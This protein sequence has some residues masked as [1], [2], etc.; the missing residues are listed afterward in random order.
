MVTAL[1]HHGWRNDLTPESA[2][3]RGGAEQDPIRLTSAAERGSELCPFRI[4]GV[5][6]A[7][8]VV[9]ERKPSEGA[10]QV[11]ATEGVRQLCAQLQKGRHR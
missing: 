1:R 7:I 5:A 6:V 9:H 3:A 8:G 10:S 4:A 11:G 2:D